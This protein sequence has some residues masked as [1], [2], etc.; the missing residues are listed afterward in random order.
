MTSASVQLVAEAVRYYSKGDEDCFFA[1]LQKIDAV[2]KFEG[3]GTSLFIECSPPP[4]SDESLRELRALFRRYGVE[5]RQLDIY[6][7]D[8]N[9]A[10]FG[11]G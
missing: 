2:K 4:I 8:A 10:W 5:T 1:W 7:T 11:R 6:L 9:R 3:S